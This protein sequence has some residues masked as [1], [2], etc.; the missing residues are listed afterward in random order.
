MALSCA[1]TLLR[2]VAMLCVLL[3]PPAAAYAADMPAPLTAAQ[4][5]SD[6]LQDELFE[7]DPAAPAGTSQAEDL[8]EADLVRRDASP[9]PHARVG[10]RPVVADDR[11]VRSLAVPPETPPRR[12]ASDRREG[13][14]EAV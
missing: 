13:T 12:L 5:V 1:R 14:P 3:L 11:P 10:R 9:L 2:L 4:S 8:P 7:E 6:P